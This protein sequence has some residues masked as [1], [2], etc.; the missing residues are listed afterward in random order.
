MSNRGIGKE[1]VRDVAFSLPLPPSVAP[2]N[3]CL[4]AAVQGV[5]AGKMIPCSSDGEAMCGT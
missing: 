2:R 1:V 4:N 3:C 5:I